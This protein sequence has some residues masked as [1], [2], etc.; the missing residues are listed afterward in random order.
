MV[1]I[2]FNKA[3]MHRVPTYDEIIKETITHPT[4]KIQLPDRMATRL[5][6]LPQ[7]TRFDDVDS[8][9][10]RSEQDKIAK[11]KLQD[12]TL[13]TNL[14]QGQTMSLARAT[15]QSHAAGGESDYATDESSLSSSTYHSA[16]PLRR[17]SH[18]P[19]GLSIGTRS[20]PAHPSD[21]PPRSMIPLNHYMN[22]QSDPSQPAAIYEDEL[23]PLFPNDQPAGSYGNLFGARHPRTLAIAGPGVGQAS[24]ALALTTNNIQ[25]SDHQHAVYTNAY[26]QHRQRRALDQQRVAQQQ[27]DASLQSQTST[28]PMLGDWLHVQP[29]YIAPVQPTITRMNT[30]PIQPTITRM[31]PAPILHRIGG[32]TDSSEADETS[33]RAGTQRIKTST[34]E[35]Q[36]S[37]AAAAQPAASSSSAAAA[38]PA[39]AP[40]APNGKQPTPSKISNKQLIIQLERAATNGVLQ[41]KQLEQ[42][43]AKSSVIQGFTRMGFPPG[44]FDL[45]FFTHYTN[46]MCM[47]RN[48]QK[49]DS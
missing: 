19:E 6:N 40:A 24:S 34:R 42:F 43:L 21:P 46:S 3:I 11:Q 25:S 12:L 13:H 22:T 16:V 28:V 29:Q 37:S 15:T 17:P 30:D 49:H 31:N 20:A 14:P 44:P 23:G 18:L 10:L 36:S 47:V 41:G 8:L 2:N 39:P 9:D 48:L 38:A 27:A 4:D 33:M 7:L 32:I 5:R 26:Q 45:H 35:R 1:A